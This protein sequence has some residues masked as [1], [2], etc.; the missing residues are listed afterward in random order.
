VEV[1]DEA[2][3]FNFHDAIILTVMFIL[4]YVLTKLM[5]VCNKFLLL[6]VMTN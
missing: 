1:G 6:I 3:K 5:S 2:I 4:S